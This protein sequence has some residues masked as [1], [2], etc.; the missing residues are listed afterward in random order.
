MKETQEKMKVSTF[1]LLRRENVS[2]MIWKEE[3]KERRAASYM[4]VNHQ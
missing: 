3:E 2:N 1:I 4:W